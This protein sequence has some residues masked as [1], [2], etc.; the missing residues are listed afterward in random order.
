MET[1]HNVQQQNKALVEKFDDAF[2]RGDHKTILGMMSEDVEWKMLGEFHLKGKN[3]IAEMFKSMED[4]GLPEIWPGTKVA[5]EDRIVSEGVMKGLDKEGKIFRA[6]YVDS[7]LI[8]NGRIIELTSY[9]VTLK[10]N[11]NE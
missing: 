3:D 9:V 5:E 4:M 6:A 1:I 11:V 7:Y 2:A 8:Q 10:E